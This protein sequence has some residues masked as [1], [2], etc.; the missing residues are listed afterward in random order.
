MSADSSADSETT[1]PSDDPE[2]VLLAHLNT[3]DRIVGARASR[4]AMSPDDHDDFRGWVRMKLMED[5]YAI[6]R[7]HQGRASLAGYLSVVIANLLRDRR[8]EKWGKW[9]PSAVARRAGP[10]GIELERLV[11]RDGLSL[12]T[13]IGILQSRTDADLDT[14]ALSRLAATFPERSRPRI[15]ADS[16]ALVR[17]EG[18]ERPDEQLLAEERSAKHRSVLEALEGSIDELED[19]DRTILKLQYWEGH[20]LADVS[21]ALH[22]KQRPLYRRVERL[23]KRLRKA[24]EEAGFTAGEIGELLGEELLGEEPT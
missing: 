23:L 21:R 2:A 3:V 7:K 10:L 15:E 13:A 9:R 22:L 19:E 14:R 12:D 24:L 18:G 1:P 17:T 4:Y 8:I 20:T 11:R 6:L 5:D 16:D